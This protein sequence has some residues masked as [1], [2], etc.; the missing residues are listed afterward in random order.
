M[1]MKNNPFDLRVVTP[2]REQRDRAAQARL[3][4]FLEGERYS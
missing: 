2:G 3:K 4:A 1:A